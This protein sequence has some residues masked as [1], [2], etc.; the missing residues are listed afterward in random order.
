MVMTTIMITMMIM[1][2]VMMMTPR[3]CFC[4][5]AVPLKVWLQV[6]FHSCATLSRN[7][8]LSRC[9]AW[10]RWT[11]RSDLFHGEDSSSLVPYPILPNQDVYGSLNVELTGGL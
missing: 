7:F 5:A 1:M 10:D 9:T 2:M 6:W 8:V 11:V 3:C 4:V